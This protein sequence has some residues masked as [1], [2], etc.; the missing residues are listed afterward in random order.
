MSTKSPNILLL[1]TDDQR[2]DTINA[3]G[4][5][6]IKTPN[7]DR[8]A[9]MGVSFKQ[10]HIPSGTSGAVCMPSRAMLMT[11]RFLHRIKG[12]GETIDA[13][14]YM[15]G[16][17]LKSNGYI[18]FGAGKWHNSPSSYNRN[19]DRG[20]CIFFGGMADHW[21]VPMF[22]YDLTGEYKGHGNYIKDPFHSNK[23]DQYNYDYKFQGQHSSKTIADAGIRFLE[24]YSNSSEMRQSPFFSYLSFLAPHDPRTMP[25]Q[26]LDMYKDTEIPLPPNFLPR[27]PFNNGWIH[28]RDEDLANH[29]RSKS[30]ILHHLREYYAMI[31]HL[32]Y[33][34]GRVIDKL[35]DSGLLENTI[36]VLA[37]DN[38]L[39]L[40]QHGLMGKQ[41]CYEHSNHVPLIVAGPG[42]A[43]NHSTDAFVYLFDIFP[44][45][46]DLLG[47][48]IP[49]TVD[50]KSFAPLLREIE[51]KSKITKYSH[52]DEIY[53]AFAE[54]MRAIKE[55]RYKLIE[56]VHKGKHV[57]TQLFDLSLDPWEMKDLAGISK[58]Q[59]EIDRLRKKMIQYRNDWQELETKWGKKFWSAYY[60]S[61]KDWIASDRSFMEANIPTTYT[62][63]QKIFG[64]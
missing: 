57:K 31:T 26:F 13:H 11:G 47:I 44:S 33:E 59:S 54:S 23:C 60:A 48:P 28:V 27:H 2:F 58:F 4:N 46:L 49:E 63:W 35:E 17:V 15:M 53:Y 1:F 12:A 42:I 37:G 64:K 16:E 7:M 56:S 10:A 52:R 43:H 21:N 22:D 25:E 8:L 32:D 3:W 61:H 19:H 38:G 9:K 20:E 62:I 50:G 45:L 34:I 55:S 40:G 29:P 24:R 6:D 5:P 14:H 51:A 39:A 30:E 18:S 41:S 36:I